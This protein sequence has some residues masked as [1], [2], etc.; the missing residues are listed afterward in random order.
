MH[1]GAACIVVT[2][3]VGLAACG[4]DR[5]EAGDVVD[6]GQDRSDRDEVGDVVDSG[7]DRSDRDEVGDVVDSGEDRSDR[8]EV[9]DV[10]DSGEDRSD[11]DEVGDVVDFGEDRSDDDGQL[12][13]RFFW[14]SEVQAEWYAV[15]VSLERYRSATAALAN[16]GFEF[17]MVTDDLDRAELSMQIEPKRE[18]VHEEEEQYVATLRAVAERLYTAAWKSVELEMD[19]ALYLY[20]GEFVHPE[21]DDL[22]YLVDLHNSIRAMSDETLAIAYAR[23]WQAFMSVASPPTVVTEFYRLESELR[24]ARRISDWLA[25]GTIRSALE[26]ARTEF[27][28]VDSFADVIRTDMDRYHD[29]EVYL[30][31]SYLATSSLAKLDA[32]DG[33]ALEV[34]ESAVR[35]RF[36]GKTPAIAID[37]IVQQ[38]RDVAKREG[39]IYSAVSSHAEAGVLAYERILFQDSLDAALD[40]QEAAIGEFETLVV[41]LSDYR[42]AVFW[43]DEEYY[44]GAII[45]APRLPIWNM[46][47]LV[48][49]AA[50]SR[51]RGRP[52]LRGVLDPMRMELRPILAEDTAA[53][54]QLFVQTRALRNEASRLFAESVTPGAKPET[55]GVD[56]ETAE[57]KPERTE[58]RSLEELL[59]LDGS[60]WHVRRMARTVENWAQILLADAGILIA[61]FGTSEAWALNRR[62]EALYGEV[63]SLIEQI[64]DRLAGYS[65]LAEL[66]AAFESAEES[67][68]LTALSAFVNSL[69]ESCRRST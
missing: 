61:E 28:E 27:Y 38:I 49:A 50:R 47:K 57:V 16:L 13:N 21:M 25:P 24:T 22:P 39:V 48:D 32:T 14:C 60:R 4:S 56:S 65:I 42:T 52:G 17:V 69:N 66:R 5:D 41:L 58:A 6:F 19:E 33:A 2:I 36:S 20:Y 18:L 12:G 3:M 55:A 10:V 40:A 64:E 30:H 1:V 53:I 59:G 62:A 26:A 15:D 9:G 31:D 51:A 68:D 44:G 63:V 46:E 67:S 37:S 54:E 45:M 35:A 23:A 11:R 29:V 43:P 8:D 34:I 7:Q